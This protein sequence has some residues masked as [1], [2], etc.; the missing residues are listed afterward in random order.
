MN[1]WCQRVEE[2]Q[3][4]MYALVY[5]PQIYE[6]CCQPLVT[7]TARKPLSTMMEWTPTGS[8]DGQLHRWQ[9]MRLTREHGG[10]LWSPVLTLAYI[11]RPEPFKKLTNY[12]AEMETHE[13]K[14]IFS[15]S[16]EYV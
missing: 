15:A 12:R 6:S 7:Q 3:N 11:A 16:A 2:K 9:V 8:K 10:R 14:W 13:Q 1:F 4:S 5:S